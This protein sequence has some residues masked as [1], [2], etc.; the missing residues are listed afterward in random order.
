MFGRWKALCRSPAAESY[1]NAKRQRLRRDGFSKVESGI[2]RDVR[3]GAGSWLAGVVVNVGRSLASNVE[4]VVEQVAEKCTLQVELSPGADVEAT[5]VLLR[6]DVG[7]AASALDP[8]NGSTAAVPN[9]ADSICLRAA[10]QL[11]SCGFL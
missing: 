5:T 9:I 7:N 1:C 8:N 10:S 3:T 4:Q 2:V 6:W 11:D